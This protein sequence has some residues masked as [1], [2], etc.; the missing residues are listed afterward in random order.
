MTGGGAAM[1]TDAVY[2][3]LSD[4]IRRRI[5]EVLHDPPVFLRE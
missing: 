5:H 4:P 1:N 2:K 3:A